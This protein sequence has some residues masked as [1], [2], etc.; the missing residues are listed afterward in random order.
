MK[1][2]TI[3]AVVILFFCTFRAEAQAFEVGTN[4]ISAGLGLGSTLNG[5]GYSSST[6]GINFQYERGIWEAGPGVISLGGYL[7]LKDTNILLPI[8]RKNGIT[9]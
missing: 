3:L 4:V 2:M 7:A 8:S 6:P 1:K 5:Y 9:P